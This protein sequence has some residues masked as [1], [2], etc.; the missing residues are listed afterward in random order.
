MTLRA[1]P[2]IMPGDKISLTVEGN[3]VYRVPDSIV[4]EQPPRDATLRVPVRFITDI[5][6]V[7]D[8]EPEIGSVCILKL[9]RFSGT[10]FTAR[11][12]ALGWAVQ[13]RNDLL[14]WRE[15]CTTY[16]IKSIVRP[17]D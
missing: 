2:E 4:I 6:K 12:T 3:L 11:R 9:D 7:I 16:F 10:L 13:N 1:T 14:S 15:L 5:Q 17:G 8:P